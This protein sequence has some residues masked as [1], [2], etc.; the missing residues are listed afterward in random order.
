MK[1]YI[2]LLRGINV[3]G[4]NRLKMEDL[5]NFLNRIGL[6]QVQTYIQSGNAVFS[7]E[8]SEAELEKEI[9]AGI[10]N[11]FD[12]EIQVFVRSPQ[13]FRK[14][15]E[16]CPL[17]HKTI[18]ENRLM[19]TFF[20]KTPDS[21]LIHKIL[22]GDYGRDVIHFKSDTS[23]F[24]SPDGYGRSK[25]SNNFLESKLKVSATTRNWKTVEKLLSMSE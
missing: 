23:Y 14:V 16:A 21:E 24:Y 4:R 7:S 1:K 3:G 13:H 8:Q 20:S 11:A 6:K 10:S 17:D 9:K 22:E 18:P 19:I 5:R 25:L 2:C 15:L 12:L